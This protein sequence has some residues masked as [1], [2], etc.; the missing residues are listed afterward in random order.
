MSYIYL[1]EKTISIYSRFSLEYGNKVYPTILALLI[2]SAL[3]NIYVNDTI[4]CCDKCREKL[5]LIINKV[6][7]KNV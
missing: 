5:C 1:E 3:L 6:V 4:K 7:Q 2:T